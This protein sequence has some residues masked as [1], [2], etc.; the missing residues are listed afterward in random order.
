MTRSNEQY[1][2]VIEKRHSN[3]YVQAVRWGNFCGGETFEVGTLFLLFRPRKRPRNVL[4]LG[5]SSLGTI[6]L[7]QSV[8]TA[9]VMCRIESWD[10]L[11]SF[12]ISGDACSAYTESKTFRARSF[13]I[14]PFLS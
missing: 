12:T 4:T 2:T 11:T 10:S 3:I 7:L 5:T 1:L 13:P 9:Q 8:R 14:G 6:G